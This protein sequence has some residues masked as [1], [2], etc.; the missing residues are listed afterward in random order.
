MCPQG[1]KDIAF[2]KQ[3][4]NSGGGVR[5]TYWSRKKKEF[6]EIKIQSRSKNFSRNQWNWKQEISREKSVKPKTISLKRSVKSVS[7]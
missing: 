2:M 1:D 5:L 4:Y 7:L 3:D 6:L